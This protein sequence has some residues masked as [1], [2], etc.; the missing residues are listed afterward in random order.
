M[1]KIKIKKKRRSQIYF[2]TES[3]MYIYTHIYF[4][5][6]Y[7]CQ[8]KKDNYIYTSDDNSFGHPKRYCCFIDTGDIYI[9][10]K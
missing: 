5:G 1:E 10:K 8:M 7:I 2:F 9:V 3:T 6:Y 4:F